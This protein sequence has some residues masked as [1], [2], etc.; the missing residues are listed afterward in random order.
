MSIS[1][2]L[3][4]LVLLGAVGLFSRNIQRVIRN[5]RLGRDQDISDRKAERWGVMARVALGQSKMVARPVAGFMHILIYIGFVIINIEVAEIVID[6]IF[7]THRIGAFLGPLYDFLIGSFEVLAVGVLLACVVFIARRAVLQLPRFHKPEM[8]GWPSKDAMIILVVEIL[9][10]GAFLKMN[11]TDQVLAARGVDHYTT[12]GSYP[13]SSMLRPFFEGMTD[14][15]V[16]AFERF[17]WWF[18]I[19]GIFAF[20]N[21]LPYSKHFHILLAF[22]NT[23]YSKLQPP[24]EIA[25]M[26][27]ITGEVRSMIDPSV[28][29][30]EPAPARTVAGVEVPERFGA[31]DVFDL[32]WK[33]L[34]DAYSCT[35]CGRCTSECPANITGK[36]LSPR[37]IMMDTR[38]RM[39]EVG[40]NIDTNQGTFKD[41][42]LSLHS[43]ITEEELWAC[44]TCNAC[45]Q[46]CPVNIDPVHIIMEMRRYKVME[47]SSTRPALTGM[48]NNVENNGAPWAFGPDQ[49]MKW[50]ES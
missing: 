4:V 23:W 1:S 9:L 29:P 21:Y 12:A 48:F 33:S 28:A 39:E 3:F 37:K 15:T 38:D 46:A 42:G 35:E 6:G 31:K 19:L 18:H 22:P 30:P 14:G 32:S 5:I 16:I 36:L 43:R 24:T 40:R 34:M 10:M 45:T 44:T 17:F 50:T 49:R 8:K 25:N 13:V 20:L 11:A 7:G 2:I 26:P 41:D 47:E 27:R